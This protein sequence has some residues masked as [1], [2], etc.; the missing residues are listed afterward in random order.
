MLIWASGWSNERPS[1]KCHALPLRAAAVN[2]R[3]LDMF[4]AGKSGSGVDGGEHSGTLIRVMAGAADCSARIGTV[5]GP[6]RCYIPARLLRDSR[7]RSAGH[8]ARYCRCSFASRRRQTNDGVSDPLRAAGK[9][10]TASRGVA[11]AI[12]CAVSQSP[13][14]DP[15]GK[16]RRPL[17]GRYRVSSAARRTCEGQSARA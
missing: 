12:V 15:G 10:G 16:R 3:L 7:A 2:A 6:I 14:R 5:Q 9:V 1:R 17:C 8:A 11:H 4:L 13:T